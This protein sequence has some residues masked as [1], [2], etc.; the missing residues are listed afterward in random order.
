MAPQQVSAS[1][2]FVVREQP[3][4]FWNVEVSVAFA[5]P[6]GVIHGETFSTST[7]SE[8]YRCLS[9]LGVNAVESPYWPYCG[10]LSR[11]PLQVAEPRTV[12]AALAEQPGLG[13]ISLSSRLGS[14]A[15]KCTRA[16]RG[17]GPAVCPLN[18]RSWA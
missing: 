1:R 3:E 18:R 10:S 9:A 16:S 4:H 8:L 15:I 13:L 17:C 6:D 12:V 11:Q 14:V 2:V 7:P 5:L